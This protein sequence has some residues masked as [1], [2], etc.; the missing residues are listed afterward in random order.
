MSIYTGNNFKFYVLYKIQASK[1]RKKMNIP[2][3]GQ[4]IT[5]KITKPAAKKLQ[6]GA[7]IDTFEKTAKN[8][9]QK[10]N[11]KFVEIIGTDSIP[12]YKSVDDFKKP[13]FGFIGKSQA[14][15]ALLHNSSDD[16]QKATLKA[17]QSEPY[18]I[19]E[20]AMKYD[21]KKTLTLGLKNSSETL[22]LKAYNNECSS[23]IFNIF[24]LLEKIH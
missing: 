24:R 3:L 14:E 7:A 2:K 18:S 1:E 13:I 15:Q 10:L 11:K 21:P 12:V 5:T 8:A 4:T 23:A 6:T 20:Y 17:I 16:I 19:S 22:K 9:V